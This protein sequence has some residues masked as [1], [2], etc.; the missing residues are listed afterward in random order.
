MIQTQFLH[1][2]P[3]QIF[4]CT[5]LAVLSSAAN[6][7]DF[8]VLPSSTARV[9]VADFG[10]KLIPRHLWLTFRDAPKRNHNVTGNNVDALVQRQVAQNWTIHM[11]DDV[12]ALTFMRTAF[13]GT[14]LLWA[15]ESIH[16]R[17]GVARADIWRY[18][19]LWYYGGVYIDDDAYIFRS[20]DEVNEPDL[21]IATSSCVM[22][23]HY[24]FRHR[25]SSRMILSF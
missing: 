17:L 22:L 16:S 12:C 11:C 24:S 10:D 9:P 2:R 4:V 20:F 21:R 14:S 3:G 18:A 1:L 7:W 25:S 5:L 13:A 6:F 19:V 8:P 15:Y 23:D